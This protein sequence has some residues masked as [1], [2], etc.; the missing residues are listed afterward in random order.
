MKIK[1]EMIKREIAGETYLVP[2]GATLKSYNG[3]FALSEVAAF[4]WDRLPDAQDESAVVDSVI[5]EYEVEPETA[6]SDVREFLAKL[7][8]MGII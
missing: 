8:E 5:A 1:Y 6:R 7:E 4:I 3:I 2:I